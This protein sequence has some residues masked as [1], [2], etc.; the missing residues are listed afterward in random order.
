M[1]S[2]FSV[3]QTFNETEIKTAY[4]FAFAKEITWNKSK[5]KEVF[6]FG[7]IG[8]KD[9]YK[10]LLS[11]ANSV[12]IDNKQVSVRFFKNIDLIEE[13]D[14]LYVGQASK[15]RLK[16]INVSIKNKNVLLVTN[17][18][19]E[20]DQ[21][22]INFKKNAENNLAFEV[23]RLN[24]ERSGFK[25][26]KELL[27]LGG[28]EM[29]VIELFKKTEE[30]LKEEML[31]SEKL[32]EEIDKKKKEIELLQG[33]TDSFSLKLKQQHYLISEQNKKISS[34]Q[35]RLSVQKNKITNKV[36]Y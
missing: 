12:K 11:K 27:L 31:H 8:D 16:E 23:N 32:K 1:K 13:V 25:I 26:S 29:D 6:L 28:T 21:L 3:C 20:L 17:E 9:I 14:V 7:V 10:E 19:R 36:I 2:G 4:L 18:S 22:M 15:V 24:L 35:N 30:T 33:N 5:E 34:H